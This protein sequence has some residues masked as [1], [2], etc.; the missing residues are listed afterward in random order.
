MTKQQQ[1]KHYAI[2]RADARYWDS[3]GRCWVT[4]LNGAYTTYRSLLVA[5]RMARR[6]VCCGFDG[7]RVDIA[8]HC[9]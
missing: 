2:A 4:E 1:T 9:A 3:R 5:Q 7:V 8:P 6:L